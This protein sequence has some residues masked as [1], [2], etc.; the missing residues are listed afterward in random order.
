MQALK[1]GPGR[2]RYLVSGGDSDKL[3]EFIDQASEDPSV[4]LL[5]TIGPQQSPH[6]AVFDMPHDTA[7][8]LAQRFKNDGSLKIEPD[9]PL[10]LFSSWQQ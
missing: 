7:A 3:I 4:S 9:S 2:G 10:S 8:A 6:T 5:D 1:G